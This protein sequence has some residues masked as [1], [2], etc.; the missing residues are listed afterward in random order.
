MD[1]TIYDRTQK[2]SYASGRA[3]FSK[4]IHVLCVA[5]ERSIKSKTPGV[6]LMAGT[7]LCARTHCEGNARTNKHGDS[8][9]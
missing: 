7:Q 2:H 4:K 5:G 8:A 3:K 1:N 9:R 6:S